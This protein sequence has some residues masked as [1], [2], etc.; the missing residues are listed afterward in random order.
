MS[1]FSTARFRGIFVAFHAC[2]D[3]NGDISTSAAKKLSRLYQ[4]VGV[5]G[6]Y[7]GG[8][9]GDGMLL[10]TEER[11]Q[12]LEAVMEEVGQEMTIIAHIGSPSTRESC[13]LAAHAEKCG[14]H[15]TS[16][17][18]S[19]YY[20]LPEASIEAH[21]TA[22]T[23]AADLPFI[24]YNIPATTGYNISMNMIHKMLQNDRVV[25]IKNSSEIAHDILRLKQAG[26]K[27]FVVFNGPD[28][29][30]LAGRMM[31]ADAGI[32]GTYG[33]M[34][35]LYLKLEDCIQKGDYEEAKRWQ[36]IITPLIY[37]LCA[38]PSLSGATKAILRFRGI[39]AGDARMPL[40]PVPQDYPGMK[41]L[42]EDIMKY[43]KEATK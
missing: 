43:T 24:I 18:P 6:L 20:R 26:G 2:Y 10:T 37:R 1:K 35:E 7:V 5:Q 34:P 31:G 8:S 32:G 25:G 9:T 23:Q 40:L 17:V 4:S 29:Q 39:D 3:A 21:W 33:A 14:A 12:M 19:I 42:Y 22:I 13:K 28:E 41:E 15:A 30:Y 16:A 38:M 11:M 27:D 36:N